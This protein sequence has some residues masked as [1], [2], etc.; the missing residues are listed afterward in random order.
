P[1]EVGEKTYIIE[2]PP[3]PGETELANNR[4]ER[5]VVVTDNKRLRVL[6]VEGYPRYEFRYVKVL[7][8]RETEAGRAVHSFD[9]NTLLLDASKDH[10]STDRTALR[11]FPT[12][13]ELFEYDVVILGDVDPDRLPRPKQ[14]T[15][16]LADFVRQRGGGLLVVAGE[17][18]VPF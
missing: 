3:A 6:F 7:L 13:N 9:L 16:D 12:R 11:G 14:T 15:Q 18:N 2:V 8:E 1:T 17:Q 4:I 5:L 10:A